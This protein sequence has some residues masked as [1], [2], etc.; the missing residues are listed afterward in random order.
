[1]KT[2]WYVQSDTIL[3]VATW[4]VDNHVFNN[5]RDLLYFFEKPWKYEELF[6]QYTQSNEENQ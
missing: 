1:M 3:A 4:G 5:Q 2:A 6:L